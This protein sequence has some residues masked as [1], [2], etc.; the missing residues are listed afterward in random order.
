MAKSRARLTDDNDPL[1]ST[2]SVFASLEQASKSG[3][4]QVS[5]TTIQEVTSLVPE[6]KVVTTTPKQNN[7]STSQQANKL[8]TQEAK[9]SAIRKST[10]QLSEEVLKQLDRYHLQLQIDLGKADAPYKEVIV[11]EAIAQFLID[12]DRTFVDRLLKRQKTR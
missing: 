11:E 2:E 10:F 5:N 9:K 1:S 4:Q 8:E 7:K 12:A 6:Q 3:S